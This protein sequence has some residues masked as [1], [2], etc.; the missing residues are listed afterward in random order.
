MW[1]DIALI[2]VGVII[3]PVLCAVADKVRGER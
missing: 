1:S 3:W 2:V